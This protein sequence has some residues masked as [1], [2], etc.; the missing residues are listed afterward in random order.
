M[1]PTQKGSNVV[2]Q[3]PT[4]SDK[5][6]NKL[7]QVT[8]KSRNT[9]FAYFFKSTFLCELL[10]LSNPQITAFDWKWSQLKK[11][12]TLSVNYQQNG[13]SYQHIQEHYI[14]LLLQIYVFVWII[15][16][17]KFKNNSVCLNMIASQDGTNI[18]SQLP[19]YCDKGTSKLV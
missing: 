17:I 14:C 1:K 12:P 16:I 7:V 4:Y 11:V 5:G 10:K 3:L 13:P 19:T 6:T 18:V 2:S 15:K 9:R 8:N